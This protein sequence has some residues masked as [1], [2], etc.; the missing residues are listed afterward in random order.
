MSYNP[1]LQSCHEQLTSQKTTAI[2]ILK[3]SLD[4]CK[5]ENPVS[6]EPKTT[7]SHFK[8]QIFPQEKTDSKHS[9]PNENLM[10]I[11]SQF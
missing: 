8:T 4:S 5:K 11:K 3:K 6:S 1:S 10:Y 2:E 7:A 9:C